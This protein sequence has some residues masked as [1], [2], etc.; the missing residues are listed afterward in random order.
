ML[1][2]S[3]TGCFS[4]DNG[5]PPPQQQLYF[6]TGLAVSPGG[7]A[8]FV[9]NSDFDLQ[10]KAGTVQALDLDRI[11]A[12]IPR[13][14]APGVRTVDADGNPTP[15]PAVIV[16]CV[17]AGLAYTPRDGRQL[18]PGPCTAIDLM[19]PPD[20]KGSLV[21]NVANIGAFGTDGVVIA[22]PSSTQGAAGAPAAASRGAR[23]FVPVRGDPSLTWFDIDD[24][25]EGGQQSFALEC[26]QGQ[27]DGRCAA[28]HKAGVDPSD[29]TREITM[30]GEPFDMAISERGDAIT[31][32]HQTSGAVSLF[33][34]GWG[35]AFDVDNSGC[36]KTVV[37]PR[38]E[39]VLGGLP[40]GV[41]AMSPLPVPQYVRENPS[42][43]YTPGFLVGYRNA[44]VLDVVRLYD[45]CAA[46]PSRP[47]LSRTRRSSISVS[48]GGYDSRGIALDARN[49]LSCEGSCPRD[50]GTSARNECLARCAGVPVDV[51]VAGRA[52]PALLVGETAGSIGP[53]GGDD[54]VV[55]RD[56]IPLS[57]GASRVVS[58]SIVDQNGAIKPRVFVLCFDARLLYVFDPDTRTIESVVTTG[59]GPS[60]LVVDPALGPSPGAPNFAY[61]AHF[62][63]SYLGVLDLD[64]RNTATYLTVIASVGTPVPPRESN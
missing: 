50:V 4:T 9:V 41:T 12:L 5:P 32:S 30:P 57:Q 31:V 8:L 49:R 7:H 21:R 11:R 27:N 17:A 23:L 25:R 51:F 47:F 52:P 60:A 45:D 37:K 3:S 14:V 22:R 36:K 24:D 28:D 61:I 54:Y 39:F 15:P 1:T 44:P 59:R 19:T 2:L 56:Q 55:F 34:N 26:G 29:N 62:T 16:D 40:L 18:Y 42:V 6:P 35:D 38:L 53:Y 20:G 43:P 48:A 64:M 63:D 13:P 58:G 10:Y 33:L 46:S